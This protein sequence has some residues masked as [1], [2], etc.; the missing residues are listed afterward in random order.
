MLQIRS[1]KSESL[2]ETALHQKISYRL[3]KHISD[4]F[5]KAKYLSEL[6]LADSTDMTVWKFERSNSYT[7]VTFDSD[8]Y[9]LS[10]VKGCPPK[11]TW[12]RIGNATSARIVKVSNEDF[13]LIKAFLTDNSYKDLSC[14]EID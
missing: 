5:P 13:E 2:D 8:F 12:L 6:G 10:M 9:D 1:E 7:I 3:T 11:I 14:L 4:K